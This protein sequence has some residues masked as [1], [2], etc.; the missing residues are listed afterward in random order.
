MVKNR[1]NSIV[2]KF[3]MNKRE[4]EADF[5]QRVLTMYENKISET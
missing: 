2:L 4:K 1:F 5:F 3:P